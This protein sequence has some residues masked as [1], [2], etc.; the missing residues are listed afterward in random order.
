MLKYFHW[1]TSL[2]FGLQREPL[3][4]VKRRGQPWGTTHARQV[5]NFISNELNAR[6]EPCGTKGI[7]NLEFEI[8]IFLNDVLT[9]KASVVFAFGVRFFILIRN[10]KFEI[11]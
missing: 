6:V 9:P 7:R 4:G 3:V 1:N 8:R 10:S 2:G 11:D 5:H